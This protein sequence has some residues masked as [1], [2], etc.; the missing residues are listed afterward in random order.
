MYDN[1]KIFE[2]E[3]IHNSHTLPDLRSYKLLGIHLDQTLSF[4]NHTKYL[5]NKL[6]KSLYCLN[7]AKCFLSQNALKTL[8][9]TLIHPTYPT[10]LLS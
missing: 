3:Q 7:R 8:Y 4:D 6:D 2:L 10:V 1:H 9:F 5:C